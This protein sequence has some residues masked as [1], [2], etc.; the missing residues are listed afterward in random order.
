MIIPLRTAAFF[1]S[2]RHI[3][4]LI[5]S[6]S[7][8]LTGSPLGLSQGRIGAKTPIEM[9]VSPFESLSVQLIRLTH[10]PQG[11]AIQVVGLSSVSLSK[12]SVQLPDRRQKVHQGSFHP[13]LCPPVDGTPRVSAGK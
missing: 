1:D 4:I 8:S 3:A 9:P 6:M 5:S 10:Y 7:H 13:R 2:M 11:P 12:R